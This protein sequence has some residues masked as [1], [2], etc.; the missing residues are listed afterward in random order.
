[1]KNILKILCLFF[2]AFLMSSGVVYSQIFWEPCAPVSTKNPIKG[3]SSLTVADNGDIWANG[4]EGIFF[5]IDNGDTWVKTTTNGL[6]IRRYPTPDSPYE[7]IENLFAS[8]VVNPVTGSVFVGGQY[9]NIHR[10]SNDGKIWEPILEIPP[11][12]KFYH[13]VSGDFFFY[14]VINDMLVTASGDIYALTYGETGTLYHSSDNGDTWTNKEFP[15][16]LPNSISQ[17]TGGN[18]LALAPDGTLYVT[19]RDGVYRLDAGVDTWVKTST[20]PAPTYVDWDEMSAN[21]IAVSAEGSVFLATGMAGVMK[22]TDKGLTWKAVNKGLDV[23]RLDYNS[24][25]HTYYAGTLVTNI[26]YNPITE[27]LFIH[28]NKNGLLYISTDLGS[29]WHDYINA[30]LPSRSGVSPAGGFAF[31]PKTGTMFISITDPTGK[32]DV[33]RSKTKEE[34]EFLMSDLPTL[35]LENYPNPFNPTTTVKYQLGENALVTLKIYDVMGREVATLIN[36]RMQFKGTTY[37]ATF[38]ARGLTSGIYFY[39]LFVNG[40]PYT[41]KMLLMK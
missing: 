24:A 20:I 16:R 28:D 9:G 5:S 15:K 40:K 27:H 3:V 29:S 11:I 1:M 7:Y 10:L 17:I 23:G 2:L 4:T 25:G 13:P 19:G 26:L 38:N 12:W 30:G 6:K 35:I 36:N 8:P 34:M 41:R 18:S 22:S 32:Y 33:Y 14:D 31:N 37:E 21:D 39:T